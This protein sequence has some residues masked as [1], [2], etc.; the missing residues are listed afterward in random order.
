MSPKRYRKIFANGYV[1]SYTV[2]IY[3]APPQCYL[4]VL[5]GGSFVTLCSCLLS[6]FYLIHVWAVCSWEGKKLT[7]TLPV[8]TYLVQSKAVVQDKS[9]YS[10]PLKNKF[11]GLSRAPEGTDRA[12]NSTNVSG[13]VF[14]ADHL[15][16][17][18]KMLE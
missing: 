15:A 9:S 6:V 8:R 17:C 11:K 16:L 1:R 18:Q 2:D 3:A 5:V 14:R 7:K 4:L 10:F 13:R 12:R